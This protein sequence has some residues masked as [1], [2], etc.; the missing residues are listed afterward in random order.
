MSNIIPLRTVAL[1]S[2]FEPY[3]RPSP[4]SQFDEKPNK[5]KLNGGFRTLALGL[6][7]SAV[8]VKICSRND[9]PAPLL[10]KLAAPLGKS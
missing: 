2:I 6:C 8:T 10:T 1:E 9:D 5:N 3:S 7:A 4:A